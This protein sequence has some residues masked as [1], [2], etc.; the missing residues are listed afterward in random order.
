MS[1]LYVFADEAGCFTFKSASGASKYFILCTIASENCSMSSDLLRMRRELNING[2]A[3]RDKLHASDDLQTTRDAVFDVLCSHDFR[4][5]A[6]ILEKRKAQPQTRPD[7]Q[8]F[9]QYAWYYHLKFICPNLLEDTEKMMITAAFLGSKKT[10]ATFKLAVNNSLQQL[11]PRSKW[12]V[13][14]MDSAKDPMLWAADY[15]AWA[16]QRKW[17]RGDDRSWQRIA[18]KIKSEFDLWRNGTT[19]YY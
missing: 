18:P 16:I 17:E 15:C 1:H 10:R 3:D 14:F 8:T 13:T 5:D 7:D 6:T 4:I 11:S 2:N 9:Y 12:E 19:T